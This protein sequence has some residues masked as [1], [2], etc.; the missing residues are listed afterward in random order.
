MGY[1]RKDAVPRIALGN[2]YR[3]S[4]DLD[5]SRGRDNPGVRYRDHCGNPYARGSASGGTADVLAGSMDI[6]EILGG[7]LRG[8][9]VLAHVSCPTCHGN[10]RAANRHGRML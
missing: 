3:H 5:T 9:H 1:N 2:S 6:R 7:E 8:F 4:A 10:V